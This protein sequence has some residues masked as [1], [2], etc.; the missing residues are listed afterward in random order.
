MKIQVRFSI[1]LT[2]AICSISVGGLYA[3]SSPSIQRAA[4]V[5]TPIVPLAVGNKWYYDA[6]EGGDGAETGLYGATQEIIG[7]TPDSFAIVHARFLYEGRVYDYAPRYWQEYQGNFF[8]ETSPTRTRPK[9]N[10]I[11]RDSVVIERISDPKLVHTITWTPITVD[12]LGSTFAGQNCLELRFNFITGTSSSTTEIASGLGVYYDSSSGGSHYT[13]LA[14]RA[15]VIGGTVLGDTSFHRFPLSAYTKHQ[16][17]FG[18]VFVGESNTDILGIVNQGS[19]SLDVTLVGPTQS[20]F[21]VIDPP[22]HTL[23]RPGVNQRLWVRFTPTE[24]RLYTDTIIVLTNSVSHPIDT[25]PLAGTGS[26][27]TGPWSIFRP[28]NLD[29]GGVPMGSSR[30]SNLILRNIGV[31]TLRVFSVSSSN[32]Q[33]A[34]ISPLVAVSPDSETALTFR[35]SPVAYGSLTSRV[36][37]FTNGS[38]SPDTISLLGRGTAPITIYSAT[39]LPFGSV[40]R[41][42][43]RQI[44]H[45]WFFNDGEATLQFDS[46]TSSDPQFSLLTTLHNLN[47]HEL[48][49]GTF[50]FAPTSIGSFTCRML[51][52]SNAL[53]S[54]D[55]FKLTGEGISASAV[56]LYT[57]WLDFGRAVK[58]TS[59]D[60]IFSVGN[61]GS[62]TLQIFSL[63]SNNPRFI[64][65]PS[66]GYVPPGNTMKLAVRFTP[67]TVGNFSSIVQMFTNTV[68]ALD[69]IKLFGTG[70]A[71]VPSTFSLSQNYPNPFNPTTTISFQIPNHKPQTLVSLKVFDLLGREVATLVNEEVKPGSY[72]RVFN[73]EGLASGV[74]LYRL[75]AGI[76]AQT[77]KLLLLR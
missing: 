6:K 69:T 8:I 25:I 28:R 14:L 22:P 1:M 72:E 7:F 49:D 2:I 55:S 77:R 15:A 29:F 63:Q 40:H 73:A 33:F 47:F 75:Q 36:L 5:D 66:E 31:D 35:F 19:L 74:Y 53:S 60:S 59:V 67:D 26:R 68:H 50:R 64:F 37:V 57:R 56:S 23:I 45:I 38:N 39:T 20:A 13:R 54:P 21:T 70:I 46:V 24:A 10:R 41:G 43:D 62:D 42:F 9:F 48:L 76:F 17:S 3:Q 71:F 16:L 52:W 11:A 30:D 18:N 51:I 61:T 65:T 34:L 32:P 12:F 44:S 58:G 4:L 27:H